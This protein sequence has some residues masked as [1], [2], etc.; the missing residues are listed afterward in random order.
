[1]SVILVGPVLIFA[2]L[3][4]SAS[5]ASH[6][7]IQKVL[8][9]QLVGSMVFI[10]GKLVP[11]FVVCGAFTFIYSF[12]PSTRVHFRSALAGGIFAAL[13][14]QTAGVGFASFIVTT[15]RYAAIYSGF[16]VLILFMI[17]VYLV[18]LQQKEVLHTGTFI[19]NSWMGSL[20]PERT[21]FWLQVLSN[22]RGRKVV[23]SMALERQLLLLPMRL[24]QCTEQ[25]FQSIEL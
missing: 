8:S 20:K 18:E 4:L 14:W 16:A 22:A 15:G 5:V 7:F 17:W 12:V 10:T 19:P 2:G 11:F 9:I 3:G 13:L 6:G 1:M 21:T 25:G 24:L 23:H